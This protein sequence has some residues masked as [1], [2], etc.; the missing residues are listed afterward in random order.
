MSSDVGCEVVCEALYRK[1]IVSVGSDLKSQ[2]FWVIIG[3][4]FDT[5]LESELFQLVVI[6]CKSKLLSSLPRSL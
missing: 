5:I 4:G 3:F 2:L 6:Y 1:E